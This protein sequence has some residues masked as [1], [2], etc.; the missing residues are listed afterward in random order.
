MRDGRRVRVLYLHGMAE[1]AT[2]P[3]P[4]ALAASKQLDFYCP[5][6]GVWHTHRNGIVLSLLRTLLPYLT[7]TALG[8]LALPVLGVRGRAWAAL[9][10]GLPSIALFCARRLV[11]AQALGRSFDAS[12]ARALSAVRAFNPDVVVG[13]SWGGALAC[14]LAVE[15]AWS[16][17]LLLLAPAHA[18]MGRIMQRPQ[19]AVPLPSRVRVVHSRADQIV[20]I[21]HSRALCRAAGVELTEVDDEPHK[22]WGIS[23]RL[24]AMVLE[25]AK[26][27]AAPG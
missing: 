22:M 23:P 2:A 12:Y 6:L 8:A 11:L 4:A 20:P 13:F 16:G 26:P 1:T 18:H 9:T 3:K 7:A 21:E 14:R 15:G 27:A 24:P 10:F 19:P 25:L 17:P 5:H